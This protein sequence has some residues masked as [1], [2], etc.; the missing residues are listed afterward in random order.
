[1]SQ[2]NVEIVKRASEL[3]ERRDWR[4]LT[5]LVDPNVELYGTVGGIEEGKILRG[6]SEIVRAFETENEEVWEEHRIEPREFIDAGDR[7]V[8]LQREYQRSKSGAELVIETATVIDLRDGRIVCMQGYM[9]P[10]DA[11]EAVG[12][13]GVADAASSRGPAAARGRHRTPR[14]RPASPGSPPRPR[15]Y[16]H[17]VEIK[18]VMR[19][20]PE[21]PQGARTVLAVLEG[22]GTVVIARRR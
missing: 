15:S 22:T 2:E 1:M 10:A 16:A 4:G 11:L 3:M 14:S 17:E 18:V 12:L 13:L 5:D 9:T 19:T 7:A 6:L 20:I 8:V 21:P